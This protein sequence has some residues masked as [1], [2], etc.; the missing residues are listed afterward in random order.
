MAIKKFKHKDLGAFYQKGDRS[1]IQPAYAKR[2]KLILDLLCAAMDANDMDFPG[3]NFHKLS[4]ELQEFYS[5]HVNGN[6]C[7]IFRFKDGQAE[8]VDLIDYH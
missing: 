1:K 3:S 5:V 4:G 7:I 2:I 6:W 8:D